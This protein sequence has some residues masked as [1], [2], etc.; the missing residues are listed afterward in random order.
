MEI[1]PCFRV[2]FCILQTLWK[3]Q[4]VSILKILKSGR[5]ALSLVTIVC[6]YCLFKEPVVFPFSAVRVF[7]LRLRHCRHPRI[8]L[9]GESV[10]AWSCLV[11][12]WKIKWS[13]V[14]GYFWCEINLVCPLM[15]Q[16]TLNLIKRSKKMLFLCYVGNGVF[17]AQLESWTKYVSLGT[18]G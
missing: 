12:I 6:V 15:W 1:L 4:G 7:R 10:E 16:M 2:V 9:F 14:G 17:D 3:Y 11:R 18:P 8:D 5:G 13:T